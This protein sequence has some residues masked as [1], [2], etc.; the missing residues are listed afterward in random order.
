MTPPRFPFWQAAWTAVCFVV[1]V[2][3]LFCVWAAIAVNDLQLRS[4][5]SLAMWVYLLAR[6]ALAL[7]SALM[8]AEARSTLAEWRRVK[9]RAI[10]SVDVECQRIDRRAPVNVTAIFRAQQEVDA[11]RAALERAVARL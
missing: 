8:I 9:L 1:T 2:F 10:T 4:L 7:D 3:M 11:A 6:S 5:F